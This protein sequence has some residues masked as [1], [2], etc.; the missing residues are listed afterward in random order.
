MYCKV[1]I[2]EKMSGI[3]RYQDDCLVFDDD[4]IFD[5]YIK[6]IYPPEMSLKCTNTPEAKVNY[7]YLTISVYRGNFNY[8]SYDKRQEFDFEVVNYPNLSGNIP[9]KPS[10]GVFIS[11]L[12]RFCHVNKMFSYFVND[13][14]I[15]VNKVIKQHFTLNILKRTFENSPKISSIYGLNLV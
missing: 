14:N 12:V 11:Q 8:R 3:F 5:N 7:L 9:N 10:Y 4:G 13:A 6:Y 1:E 2:V 15:L